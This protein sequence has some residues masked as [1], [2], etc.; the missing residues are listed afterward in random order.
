MLYFFHGRVA[1][2]VSHGIVKERAVPPKEIDLALHR[3]AKFERGPGRH[4]AD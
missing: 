1:A 3:K 4:R 2:V